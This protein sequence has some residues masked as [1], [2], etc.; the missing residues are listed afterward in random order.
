MSHPCEFTG[1]LGLES[2]AALI[3]SRHLG[4]PSPAARARARQ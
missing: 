3:L 1:F 4:R 2:A